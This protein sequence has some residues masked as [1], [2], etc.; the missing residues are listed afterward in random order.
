MFCLQRYLT[1]FRIDLLLSA[2]LQFYLTRTAA[3]QLPLDTCLRQFNIRRATV[4]DHAH[5]AP[6]RFA[7]SGDAKELAKGV[8]HV[9]RNIAILGCLGE[10][11]SRLLKSQLDRRDA[12]LPHSRDGR[13]IVSCSCEQEPSKAVATAAAPARTAQWTL[14]SV[15]ERESDPARD[16]KT[17]FRAGAL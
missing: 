16:P 4:D 17:R 12:C 2:A 11:A 6:V 10:Q 1:E 14:S 8:T 5:A 7:K 3:V 13:S 9:G 15:H